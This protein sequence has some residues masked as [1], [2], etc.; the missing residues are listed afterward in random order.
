MDNLRAYI[1]KIGAIYIDIPF[2]QKLLTFSFRYDNINT[3]G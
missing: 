3:H 1:M 2:I